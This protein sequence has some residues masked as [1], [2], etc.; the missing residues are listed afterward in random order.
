[1]TLRWILATVHLLALGVGL[2]AVWARAYWLGRA[3]E[4]TALVRVLTADAW[5][6]GAA[7]LWFST[8]LW[9]L[10]AGMEKAPAYY[11]GATSFWIKMGALALIL[12]LELWPMITLVGWRVAVG[13]G[14]APDL[15]RAATFRAMSLAQTALL[16][17]MVLAATAMARG[18]GA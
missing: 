17:V 3:Q 12:A 13:V 15:R 10:M 18:I 14:E 16:L 9:R 7:L 5:W 1:M 2:G 11:L 8:G 4:A 6:G